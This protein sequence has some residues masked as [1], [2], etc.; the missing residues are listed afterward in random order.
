MEASNFI[1]L[2][3][4]DIEGA[5]NNMK[6]DYIHNVIH[7]FGIFSIVMNELMEC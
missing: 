5:F 7:A 1:F 6:I 4:L 2:A 3:F